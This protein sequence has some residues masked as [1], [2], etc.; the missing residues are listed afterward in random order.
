M[1][2]EALAGSSARRFFA[3]HAQSC[4]GTGLANLALPLLA[5]DRFGTAW[6]VSAVLLPDLLPAIVLGP[7]LGALVDRAGWRR[8]AAAADVLRCIAFIVVLSASGLPMMIVGATLAGLGSA[9]FHPAA[10]SGLPRLAPGERRAAAMGLFSALDDLGLTVGPALAGVLLTVTGP[11]TLLGINAA[12]FGLSALLILSAATRADRARTRSGA[13]SARSLLDAARTGIR[14]ITA[15]PEIRTL[16]SSSSGV[17][18]CIGVTSVGEVVLA[19]QTLGT[20]GSGLAVMV[21]AGGIG[22]VLGSL[23][24]RFTT[25]GPWAWR[26]AYVIGLVAMAVELIACAALPIFWLVV[27]ALAIGGFGNGLALVHDRLLL[28]DGTPEHLHGRLFAFQRTCISLAFAVSFVTAGGLIAL[29]G[30]RLAFLTCGLSLIAV[31]TL[32]IPRLRAA[33]PAPSY[34]PSPA[35]DALAYS[36]PGEIAQLVEHTTENRGVPGSSPGLAIPRKTVG[37]IA[38][39]LLL[40]AIQLFRTA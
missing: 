2:R 14:E 40:A 35:R 28:A 15:R 3:A 24:A 16:I 7:L 38:S 26:R 20:G 31:I 10:L 33:W 8:C 30:A 1:F 25:A 34:H 36:A 6:A 21:T 5:Y 17:V 29:G 12:T 37:G 9:L 4:L 19:R 23:S 11:G 27:P 39:L 32:A 13:P 18:S 22:T